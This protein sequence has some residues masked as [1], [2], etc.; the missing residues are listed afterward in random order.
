DKVYGTARKINKGVRLDEVRNFLQGEHTYT[1]H[2]P[3]RHRY[4]RLKTLPTG[5]GEWQCD[6]AIFDKLAQSNNGYKYL[7]VCINILTHK[8]MVSP[9]R[10]KRS[11]DMITAFNRVILKNKAPF[12]P[13]RINTDMGLEFEA[14]KVKEYFVKMGI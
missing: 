6:L 5:P 1:L 3:K 4:Q 2:K 13:T 7:L 9:V 10:S 11:D 12:P 8:I 14:K